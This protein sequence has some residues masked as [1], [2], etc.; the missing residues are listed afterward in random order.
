MKLFVIGAFLTLAAVATLTAAP[1]DKS[2]TVKVEQEKFLPGT[3]IKVKFIEVVEDG[4]CPSDVRC[5][6]AGN[7][8]IKLHFSKGSDKEEV[9]LNTTIKPRTIEFGGYRF[10]LTGLAPYPR[11]NVRINR[12]GYVATLSAKR[13]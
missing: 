2:V 5:V 3:R 10:K 13:L 12:L 11:S 9:E 8:K 4:R 1:Q 7:A 6:W